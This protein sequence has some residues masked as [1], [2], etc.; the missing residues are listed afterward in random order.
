VEGTDGLKML[1]GFDD[2][3]DEGG[4]VGGVGSEAVTRGEGALDVK[5]ELSFEFE[6]A[7]SSAMDNAGWVCVS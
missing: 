6:L 5:P 7:R 2:T 1:V 3:L 4:S